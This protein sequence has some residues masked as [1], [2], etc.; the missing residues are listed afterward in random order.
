VRGDRLRLE[1]LGLGIRSPL[2]SAL[3]AAFSGLVGL[4]FRS[5]GLIRRLRFAI[6]H[7]DTVRSEVRGKSL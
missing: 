3:K 1:G 5:P 6:Y 4:P 7:P 2:G